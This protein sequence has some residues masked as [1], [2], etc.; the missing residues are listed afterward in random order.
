MC[1]VPYRR[2][3]SGD[4]I[5]QTVKDGVDVLCGACTGSHGGTVT[6]VKSK[7]LYMKLTVLVQTFHG[8]I[9]GYG[10]KELYYSH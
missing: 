9:H 10:S 2:A 8:G 5:P 3:E 4:H 6:I 7:L 1:L